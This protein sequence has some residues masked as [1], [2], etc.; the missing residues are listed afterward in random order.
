MD[1]LVGAVVPPGGEVVVRRA[2]RRQVVRQQGPLTAGPGLVKDRVHD[3]P[4]RIAALVAAHG[5]V[6]VLPGREHRLDQRPLLVGQV[7]LV[8]LAFTH[9]TD[10]S[11]PPAPDRNVPASPT[12][13]GDTRTTHRLT[14]RPLRR[15]RSPCA[16]RRPAKQY[17]RPDS[18][19]PAPWW[20]GLSRLHRRDHTPSNAQDLWIGFG[21]GAEGVPSRII[22]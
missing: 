13:S 4:H 22:L 5:T 1:L 12:P 17:A 2:L 19:L 11:R 21:L 3:L 14:N 9:P 7:A 6:P 18:P 10:P 8:R 15:P 20:R 16:P